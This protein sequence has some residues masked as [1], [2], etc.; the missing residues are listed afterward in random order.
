M[1]A[2]ISF[3]LKMAYPIVNKSCIKRCFYKI[4]L[5]TIIPKVRKYSKISSFHERFNTT[6]PDAQFC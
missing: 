3:F 2:S 6:G 4:N 5:R 1:Y